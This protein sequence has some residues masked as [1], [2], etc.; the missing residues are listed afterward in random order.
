M[1]YHFIRIFHFQPVFKQQVNFT[2]RSWVKLFT[3]SRTQLLPK[4][5]RYFAILYDRLRYFEFLI[6]SLVRFEMTSYSDFVTSKKYYLVATHLI[7]E[8]SSRITKNALHSS[9]GSALLNLFHLCSYLCCKILFLFLKTFTRLKT[10]KLLKSK[11]AALCLCNRLHILLYALLVF[12]LYI[13]LLKQA[14]FF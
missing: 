2:L 1:P 6:K 3:H 9:N 14:Y 11:L 8:F 4:S 12:S 5:S 10:N 7:C 13:K